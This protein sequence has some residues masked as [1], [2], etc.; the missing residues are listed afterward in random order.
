MESRKQPWTVYNAGGGTLQ[1]KKRNQ[2]D[3]IYGEHNVVMIYR[4][5]SRKIMLVS[6][7][8]GYGRYG[9]FQLAIWMIRQAWHASYGGT[10]LAA[11]A[12]L[13]KSKVYAM[14]PQSSKAYLRMRIIRT[15]LTWRTVFAAGEEN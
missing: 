3:M 10:F 9:K 2:P 5:C 8:R 7:V 12:K 14:H 4:C 11:M 6:L 15:P 13:T 1:T